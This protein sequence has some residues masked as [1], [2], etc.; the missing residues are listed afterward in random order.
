MEYYT[1]ITNITDIVSFSN[2]PTFWKGLI[3]I[4]GLSIIVFII[5]LI[6]A[7]SLMY[8]SK[9]QKKVNLDEFDDF[10]NEFENGKI[11]EEKNNYPVLPKIKDLQLS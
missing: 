10:L 6:I 11:S 8:E 3:V 1:N 7:I 4:G 2:L 5:L 9:V